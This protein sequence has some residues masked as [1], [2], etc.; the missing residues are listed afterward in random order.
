MSIAPTGSIS[1]I[2]KGIQVG[3]KNYIGV[4]GGVEPIF[5]LYY[6]RRTESFKKNE[7]Y[8]VFHSTVQAYID[9]MDLR[10]ELEAADKIEDIL[11]DYF[12][13]TAH[14]IKPDKRVEIQGLIQRYIDHS[15]SSTINLPEDVQPEVISD[16]YLKAWKK[17]L[18]G[19]TI[20]R[21]GSRFP[22]LSTET[23]LTEFQ[24][25]KENEFK[26]SVDGDEIITANGE[27]I[28]K[29]PDGTLT[30]VY[31]YMKNSDM[32]IEEVLTNTEFEEIET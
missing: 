13:R 32:A 30:T 15:I 17:D 3:G 19:V 28:I 18:K 9:K 10:E 25:I 27:E 1:N 24:K 26:I 11:P 14:H 4:S 22:I 21:D 2:I 29:L 31:H 7:F 8:K 20:Y 23:E 6:T 5:A 16:I 12:L